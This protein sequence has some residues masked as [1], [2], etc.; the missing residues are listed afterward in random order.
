MAIYVWLI[1]LLDS[2]SKMTLKEISQAW[3]RSSL[4][5]GEELP[6][7]TFNYNRN[8]IREI[9]GINIVYDKRAGSIPSNKTPY[10]QKLR[11]TG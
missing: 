3:S 1:N 10:H 7:S 9:L 6:R 5:F 11:K 2:K 8:A 4:S